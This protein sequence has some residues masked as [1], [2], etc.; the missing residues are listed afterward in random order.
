M[1]LSMMDWN[2]FQKLKME[3]FHETAWMKKDHATTSPNILALIDHFNTVSNWVK[4]TLLTIVQRKERVKIMRKFI[5]LAYVLKQMR[6]Y[7]GVIAILAG[8]DSGPIYR[9]KKTMDGIASNKKYSNLMADLRAL[10]NPRKNWVS[11]REAIR[12]DLLAGSECPTPVIP[13]LGMLLSDLVF[14]DEGNPSMTGGTYS[15]NVSWNVSKCFV[16]RINVI[17]AVLTSN[18]LRII[19]RI[20]SQRFSTSAVP[21]AEI[22]SILLCAADVKED[23]L[24][25][26]SA[27][28]E[29]KEGTPLPP[30]PMLLERF[31]P[32]QE[33]CLFV[34]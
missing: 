31:A 32:P 34:F 14:I 3:E 7:S 10:T 20:A 21:N 11:L 17:K 13:Y 26:A 6:N 2:Y 24:Y 23:N 22:Q 9:L 30:T 5:Q 12:D 4:V 29:P 15:H 16:G 33:V 8:I 19:A 25:E 1:Q 18:V 27:Y 28:I